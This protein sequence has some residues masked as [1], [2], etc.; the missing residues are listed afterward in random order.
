MITTS[1]ILMGAVV[2]TRANMR[3]WLIALGW[4]G[5]GFPDTSMFIMVA[6]SRMGLA[7]SSNLWRKPD[8]LYWNEPWSTLTDMLHSIPIW[9]A[10]ALLGYLLWRRTSGL[11]VNV[12]LALLVFSTGAFL[13]SI[14]DM[15]THT[16]DAHAHFLPLSDWH[17]NSPVSYW[18]RDH[19]G[20]EFGIFE[21]FLNVGIVGYLIWQFKQWPVRI[22]AVLMA[23]PPM[24]MAVVARMFF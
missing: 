9:G 13:H 5:G 17:F 21:I 3:P 15:L 19:Y 14:A 20:R 4:L 1:H 23:L 10:I 12:G 11:W 16:N 2:T 24:L 8:G 22:I 6:A 18:Q 7:G